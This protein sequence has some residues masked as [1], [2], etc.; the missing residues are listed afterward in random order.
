MFINGI[1]YN[2]LY[3]VDDVAYAIRRYDSRYV[4]IKHSTA[5]HS[6]I[7]LAG[8][9][10]APKILDTTSDTLVM[11][12]MDGTINLLWYCITDAQK[13]IC[14]QSLN[15]F[16]Q[17]L[18]DL[19][20]CVRHTH[21]IGFKEYAPGQF[22]FKVLDVDQ[23]ER[24]PN[25]GF[26]TQGQ[27]NIDFSIII[28]SDI[29]DTYERS[30]LSHIPYKTHIDVYSRNFALEIHRLTS[31]PVYVIILQNDTPAHYVVRLPGGNW[32]LD[33]N[34]FNSMPYHVWYWTQYFITCGIRDP[35]VDFMPFISYVPYEINI[36]TTKLA[37]SILAA[38]SY[39][40]EV[41]I[42]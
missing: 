40:R 24:C 21:N 23:L 33:I 10:L 9:N 17:G 4:V 25:H 1:E 39:D 22:E 32:Y 11:E 18:R 16:L 42:Y 36:T 5:Q 37:L 14:E 31:W 38:L 7:M 19:G 35:K 26:L 6:Q 15:H 28:E 20:Y 27:K 8:S 12:K 13:I 29:I 34:G 41:N 3:I 2:I 30:A